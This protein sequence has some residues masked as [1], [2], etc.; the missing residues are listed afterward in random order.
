MHRWTFL[1]RLI[2]FVPLSLGLGVVAATAADDASI[3]GAVVDPLGAR[4]T[5]ATVTL[6]R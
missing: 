2:L 4:V 3:K 1:R 6:L 5:G